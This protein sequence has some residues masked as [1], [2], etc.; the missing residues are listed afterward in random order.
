[1]SELATQ[2]AIHLF[3]ENMDTEEVRYYMRDAGYDS[4]TTATAINR[5]M[6]VLDLE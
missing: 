5:A 1:M 4:M 6:E 3:E 2:Y